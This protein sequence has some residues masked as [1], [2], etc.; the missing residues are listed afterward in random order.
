M[1]IALQRHW[2]AC[3]ILLAVLP[4]AGCGNMGAENVALAATALKASDA[5]L[6]IYRTSNLV[7]SVGAASVK[8]D[9]REVASLGVGG[10]TMLDVPAGS[11]KVVV[12]HWGHPNVYSITLDAKPGMLYTLEVSPRMEAA[13]AGV[14]FGLVGFAAEAAANQ[15]GGTYEVQVVDAAPLRR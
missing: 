12:G 14:A 2:I 3:A 15:N 11:H 6:K 1:P 9:G 5:R 4:V 10:S 7:A 13:V 8:V